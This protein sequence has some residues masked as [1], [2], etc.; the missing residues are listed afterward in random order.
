M[1][2]GLDLDGVLSHTRERLIRWYNK[3]YDGSLTIHS[4][5]GGVP[6]EDV[7]GVSL[8]KMDEILESF[9]RDEMFSIK[10]IKSSQ[11]YVQRSSHSFCVITRRSPAVQKPTKKW[12]KMHYGAI[13]VFH[14][15]KLNDGKMVRIP[16]STLCKQ[17]EAGL[18]V[19]DSPHHVQEVS[20]TGIQ[21]ILYVEPWNEHSPFANKIGSLQ[22][23]GRFT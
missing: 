16:K 13:P 17:N 12:V 14:A 15:A 8:E 21:S 11:R 19:D 6:M 1:R 2:I 20:N 3:T 10:P 7:F 4:W 5:R 22:E 23:L 9:L 18:F